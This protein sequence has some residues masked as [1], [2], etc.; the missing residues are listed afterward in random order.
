MEKILIVD[1]EYEMRKLLSLYL[2]Q[3]S[4]EIDEAKN[5]EEAYM[6]VLSDSYDLIILD[7]MMPIMDGLQALQNIRKISDVP[8]I[9]LTAKDKTEDKVKGFTTGADDYLVKPFEEAELVARVQALLR[10]TRNYMNE[11]KIL[12]YKSI[13]INTLSRLVTYKDVCI[14]LTQTEFDILKI[15]IQ[16]KG[17]VF[18]REQI[19]DYI[20]GLDFKGD[21]RTIDSHIKNIREKLKK[22]GIS[23]TIIKTV[24]G[25]G[26][27]IQ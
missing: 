9:L 21:D 18:S 23:D 3:Y 11:E 22:S 4:Y 20:W 25:I 7:I 16:Y 14:N 2:R 12:K 26:Y 27:T 19:I 13:N 24:W 5:G 8:T 1:D 17:K 15:L 6:K 10:R